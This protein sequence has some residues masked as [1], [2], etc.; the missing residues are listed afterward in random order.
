MVNNVN[1]KRKTQSLCIVCKQRVPAEVYKKDEKIFLKK[2]CPEHGD[3]EVF[4]GRADYYESLDEFFCLI[5]TNKNKHMPTLE[6]IVNF[7][8]NMNC[9]ICYLGPQRK[10]LSKFSPTLNELEDFIK[11]TKYYSF[12][13]SGAEATCRDDLLEIIKLLKKYGKTVSINTNALKLAD[14]KY[15]KKMKKAG[16]D[17]VNIQFSGFNEKAEKIFRGENYIEIRIQAMENL[18]K[19]GIS[20]GLNTLIAGSLNEND[21]IRVLEFGLKYKSLRMINFSTLIFVGETMDYPLNYYLMPDDLMMLVEKQT[22]GKIK[23]ENLYIFKKLEIVISSFLNKDTCFYRHAYLLI[24]KGKNYF[25]I[26]NFINLKKLEPY[27]ECYKN[28]FKKNK[29]L[30]KTFL[31]VMTPYLLIINYKILKILSEV[32]RMIISYFFKRWLFLQ[33]SDIVYLQFSAVCDLY[34]IDYDLF[35]SCQ[36]K[37]IFFFD[38][39]NNKFFKKS[40]PIEDHYWL[41]WRDRDN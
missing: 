23:R 35:K 25:P 39:E 9:P 21:I 31:I 22:K 3:M 15:A 16:I 36:C 14:Y 32:T 5:R 30:G 26:D 4:L 12:V 7:D 27:L 18:N 20:M 6:L 13:I 37:T 28:L 11:Q 1:I 17:R 8:C 2:I 19:L 10:E 33:S 24:K 34:K 38:R 29:F 40:K 41:L